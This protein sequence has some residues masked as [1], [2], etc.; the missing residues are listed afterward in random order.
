MVDWKSIFFLYFCAI[1]RPFIT[2]LQRY[3]TKCLLVHRKRGKS[4]SDPLFRGY[5]YLFHRREITSTSISPHINLYTVQANREYFYFTDRNGL[6]SIP[7][8]WSRN[9]F[10]CFRLKNKNQ[11]EVINAKVPEWR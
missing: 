11:F 9:E 2:L 8:S 3:P 4:F 7:Q 1:Y 10:H 5:G 6:G